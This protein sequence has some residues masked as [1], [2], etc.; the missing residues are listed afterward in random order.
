MMWTSEH[1]K[2][3]DTL[4]SAVIP[5]IWNERNAR[6]FCRT[7]IHLDQLLQRGLKPRLNFKS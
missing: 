5:E 7:F 3:F 6:V 1:R 2:G 4:F